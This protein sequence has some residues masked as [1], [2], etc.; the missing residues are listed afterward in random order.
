MSPEKYFH[1]DKPTETTTKVI[2]LYNNIIHSY[3]FIMIFEDDNKLRKFWVASDRNKFKFM[4]EIKVSEY[5]SI[6]RE[7]GNFWPISAE[8]S[9]DPN[10]NDYTVKYR[11]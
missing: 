3:I 9:Y 4:M 7:V 10:K 5:I 11:K 8:F 6:L 2:D 1:L